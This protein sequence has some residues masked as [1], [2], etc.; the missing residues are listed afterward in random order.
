M[1]LDAS[2][3]DSSEPVVTLEFGLTQAEAVQGALFDVLCWIRGWRAGASEQALGNDPIG[4]ETLRD[5]NFVLKRAIETE[6]QRNDKWAR[7]RIS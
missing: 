5:L 2:S 3:R 1:S 7:L 4:T 6:T